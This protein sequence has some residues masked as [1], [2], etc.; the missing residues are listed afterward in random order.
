MTSCDRPLITAAL[1]LSVIV[2]AMLFAFVFVPFAGAAG[3][4]GGG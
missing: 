2:V 4:C 1:L 3:G